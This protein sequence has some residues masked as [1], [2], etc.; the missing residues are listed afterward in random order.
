M[1]FVRKW[2]GLIALVLLISYSLMWVPR[3]TAVFAAIAAG[4][5]LYGFLR[6]ASKRGRGEAPAREADAG[7]AVERE[8]ARPRAR[9]ALGHVDDVRLAAVV[10]MI[11]LVRT[12]TTLTAAGRAL[13]YDF[14]ADPLE[15]EGRQA[16]FEEAWRLTERGRVFWPMANDLV[17]LFMT[18]LTLDERNNARR[19]RE[20]RRF[21]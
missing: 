6:L 3:S 19:A 14:M 4:A 9:G 5:G 10:L 11:Q 12:S 21:P 13:I 1:E 20:R 7:H 17:P 2:A 15:V 8:V 18:H 16:M